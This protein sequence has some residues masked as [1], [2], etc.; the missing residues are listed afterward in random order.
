MDALSATQLGHLIFALA[1]IPSVLVMLAL[2]ALWV[3][4]IRR[5]LAQ[6]TIAPQPTRVSARA[7]MAVVLSLTGHVAERAG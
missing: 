1:V 2:V 6:R 3:R 5:V 4:A 7:R